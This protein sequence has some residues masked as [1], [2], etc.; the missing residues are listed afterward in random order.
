MGRGSWHMYWQRKNHTPKKLCSQLSCWDSFAIFRE[1]LTYISDH[2]NKIYVSLED[3][4]FRGSCAG[5]PFFLKVSSQKCHFGGFRY[6]FHCTSCSVR[7]R[8]LYF[9]NGHL[10]C[11][12]CLNLGYYSQ[13]LKPSDRFIETMFKLKNYLRAKNYCFEDRTNEKRPRRMWN[14]TYDKIQSRIADLYWKSSRALYI[15]YSELRNDEVFQ[16]IFEPL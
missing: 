7:M 4:G 14:R 12:R 8:K 11:R 16:D 3:G 1:K 2:C 6:Y 13:R 5:W 10:E 15:R 9:F